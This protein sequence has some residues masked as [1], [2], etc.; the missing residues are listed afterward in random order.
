MG[1]GLQKAF[2][3]G[4]SEI[5]HIAGSCDG[6]PGEG[7]CPPDDR[8]PH[9]ADVRGNGPLPCPAAAASARGIWPDMGMRMRHW[10]QHAVGCLLLASAPGLAGCTAAKSQPGPATYVG[11]RSCNSCGHENIYRKWSNSL[12]S[13]MIREVS[14]ATVL[15]DFNDRYFSHER[16]NFRMYH[17]NGGFFV[18]EESPSGN[19]TLYRIDYTL[20]SKRIQHYISS[21]PDGSLRI[22][23]PTWDVLAQKWIHSSDIIRGA[24]HS[25]DGLVQSIQIWNKYCWNCHTS[26]EDEGFDIENNTFKTRFTESGINCEMC[27]GPG[28]GHV[29]VTKKTGVFGR[30]FGVRGDLAIVNPGRMSGEDRM[31]DCLQCH[32]RRMVV[33]RGFQTGENYYDYYMLRFIELTTRSA[34]EPEIWYERHRR[35]ANECMVI[36]ESGCYLKGNATCFTCHDPHDVNMSADERYRK[37]DEL[38]LQCHNK[39]RASQAAAEH[40]HHDP[41]KEGGR[42]VDCHM[43]LITSKNIKLLQGVA[44]RDHGISIPIPEN[45]RKHSIPNAC[46]NACHEDKSLDWV[47][48]WMD[49]WYPA[50]PRGDRF[51]DAIA[52]ARARDPAAVPLLAA[53]AAAESPSKRMRAGATAFLGEFGGPQA[54]AVLVKNLDDPDPQIRAEAARSLSEV[55]SPDALLPLKQRLSD[56]VRIVRLNA[57]FALLKMGILSEDGGFAGPFQSAKGEYLAFLREFPTVYET[58]VDLGTYLALHGE[59]KLAL[60]EYENAV[61]LRPERPLAYYYLGVTYA[62]LGM[63]EEAVTGFRRT[64]E[65]DPQF[66]NARQL[67]DQVLAAIRKGPDQP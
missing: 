38:C 54:S 48:S 43:M 52:L 55:R 58:R 26:Q 36:Q 32:V 3:S 53:F 16:W 60:K 49:K 47:V 66:R 13:H 46:N 19:L 39:F 9:T 57:V 21:R 44:M 56:P 23:F 27:H 37:T 4:E 33:K 25:D 24:H 5:G 28:S 64:L 8:R 30:L 14:P 62:R 45:S 15:A 10:Y 18:R 42:C 2:C 67:L 40:A 29:E 63:L 17:E 61:K 34:G 22:V 1:C 12:H 59:Y 50:R 51:V 6:A 35:F 7:V 31:K 65:I 41:K 11:S 20:G